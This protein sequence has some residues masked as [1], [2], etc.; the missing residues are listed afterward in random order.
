[1]S[2]KEFFI[3]KQFVKDIFDVG[4]AFAK[5]SLKN[6]ICPSTALPD[7][8]FQYCELHNFTYEDVFDTVHNHHTISK[9]SMGGVTDDGKNVSFQFD[10]KEW[11]F[12]KA[13]ATVT[14]LHE[15]GHMI[16]TMYAIN[17]LKEPN[18]SWYFPGLVGDKRNE[19]KV[20]KYLI[21]SNKFMQRTE[22]EVMNEVWA[23]LFGNAA[24]HYIHENKD[25]SLVKKLELTK[26]D[27]KACHKS[28]KKVDYA[29]PLI[30]N[31]IKLGFDY[32]K[33][34]I[35]SRYFPNEER[36]RMFW[37]LVHNQAEASNLNPHFFI[38]PKYE[39]HIARPAKA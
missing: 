38:K 32:E 20:R 8:F 11:K 29:D 23:T 33:P 12:G 22:S 5:V 2:K 21:F 6:L 10:E 30:L 1:M 9:N 17:Y 16:S 37:N 36:L 35:H 34:K 4:Y 39:K 13:H 15:F 31:A 19:I 18:R 3:S 24:F 28:A 7:T 26:E 14:L 27:L 25:T